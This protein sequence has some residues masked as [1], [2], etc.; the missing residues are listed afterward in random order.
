MN[1]SMRKQNGAILIISLLFLVVL[2]IISISSLSS[3]VVQAK[4]TS[5]AQNIMLSFR[6]SETSLRVAEDYI[7]NMTELPD[8]FDDCSSNCN[9]IWNQG[10]LASL[11]GGEYGDR[12]W[13]I[14]NSLTNGTFWSTRGHTMIGADSLSSVSLVSEQPIFFIEEQ[15][16]I[17]D[18]LNPNTSA[19]GK[20]LRFYRI[21]SKGVGGENAEGGVN[22]SQ[23][24]LQS[25]YSKRFN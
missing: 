14:P 22:A 4:T 2:T 21:T 10:S 15:A 5:N 11:Y 19:K 23:T 25:I 20:G 24:Y 13:A 6:A 9:G 18:D 12:W 3:T 17:P 8:Y 16:F 7:A 1:P